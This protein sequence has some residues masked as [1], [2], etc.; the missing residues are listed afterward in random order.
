MKDLVVIGA[1]PAGLTAAIY[2]ARAGLDF[3]VLEQD[4][5]GGGQIVSSHEVQNYPGVG[6]LSGEALGEAFRNQALELGAE[7]QYGVVES[8]IRQ[9]NGFRIQLQDDETLESKTVIAATGA[10]PAALG[11]P[12]ETEYT[13]NNISYCA[14]CDGSLYKGKNV[15]VIGG[16]DT[17]VEDALYLSAICKQV[18]IALR[19]S[20]FQCGTAEKPGEYPDSGE[21]KT[22]PHRRREKS[23]KIHT[24]TGKPGKRG[25]LRR[26]IHCCGNPSCIRLSEGTSAEI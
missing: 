21:Y 7:I 16:G 3:T 9:E 24:G 22:D 4:G 17:A 25:D 11:I 23:G 19:S 13:G 26:R 10:V 18:T 14:L 5:Y 6:K 20:R 8:V 15:L 12:G 1:G 2:A